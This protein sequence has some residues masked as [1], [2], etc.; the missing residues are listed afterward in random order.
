MS[1]QGKA[2][3]NGCKRKL[4]FKNVK[5][6][7]HVPESQLRAVLKSKELREEQIEFL[8]ELLSIEADRN[9]KRLENPD[10]NEL[11]MQ[12]KIFC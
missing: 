5:D 12:G 7:I 3:T 11:Y 1:T 8:C 10:Y 2:N 9:K 4:S 6:S